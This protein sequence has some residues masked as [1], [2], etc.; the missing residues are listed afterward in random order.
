MTPPFAAEAVVV[1]TPTPTPATAT[2]E[3]KL[4]ADNAPAPSTAGGVVRG[5]VADND[6]DDGNGAPTPTIP[7]LGEVVVSSV[8]DDVFCFLVELPASASASLLLRL[9]GRESIN[10][11]TECNVLVG[12]DMI[13]LYFMLIQ[14][15]FVVTM[16]VVIKGK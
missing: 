9:R 8:E 13:V 4:E 15:F 14:L 10:S 1:V 11:S 6:D 5:T 7:L 16:L 2:E 3:S 12:V